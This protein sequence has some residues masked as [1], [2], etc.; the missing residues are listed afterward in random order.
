MT[1]L[2]TATFTLHLVVVGARAALS[3]LRRRRSATSATAV[4]SPPRPL[5]EADGDGE[6]DADGDGDDHGTGDD[7]DGVPLLRPST[8]ATGGVEVALEP[9]VDGAAFA[10]APAP[11]PFTLREVGDGPTALPRALRGSPYRPPPSLTRTGA[12]G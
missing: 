7:G 12:G 9:V 3:A 6:P 2:S 4:D 8:A 10:A 5:R 11:K 1:Y